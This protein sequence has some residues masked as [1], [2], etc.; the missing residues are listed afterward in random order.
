MFTFDSLFINVCSG[1]VLEGKPIHTYNFSEKAKYLGKNV[2]KLKIFWKRA[3][4]YMLLSHKINCYKRPL[5]FY[6]WPVMLAC[7]EIF[8]RAT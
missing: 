1:P 6:D 4:E 3:G 5:M 7:Q 8:G 2:Q